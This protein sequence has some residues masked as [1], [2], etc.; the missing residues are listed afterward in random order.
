[1]SGR[2]EWRGLAE[3]RQQLRELPQDL[4]NEAVAIV[5]AHAEEAARA[6]RAGYPE[7]KTGNLRRG[8]TVE[9]NSSKFGASAI[10]RSRAKHAHLFEKGTKD[11]YTGGPNDWSSR[12]AQRF[13]FKAK[14]GLIKPSRPAYRGA[15]PAAQPSEA[16]V[17]KAIRA[18]RRM[19]EALLDLVRRAGFVVEGE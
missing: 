13:A 2:L 7:G 5:R 18:R 16:M 1:M 14:H 11:R 8:V 6:I 12:R 19:H 15:M 10:V 9:S 3:L 17:P 4:N